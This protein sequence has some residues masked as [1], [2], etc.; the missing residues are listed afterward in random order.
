MLQNA[1][2]LSKVMSSDARKAPLKSRVSLTRS[3]KQPAYCHWPPIIAGMLGLRGDIIVVEDGLEEALVEVRV[4]DAVVLVPRLL[5]DILEELDKREEDV[6]NT[7]ELEGVE[8]PITMLEETGVL[9]DNVEVT[10]LEDATL[11]VDVVATGA[12]DLELELGALRDR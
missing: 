5:L 9:E 7:R 4:D 6:L 12:E 2:H 11:V 8:L 3:L 1:A 10:A